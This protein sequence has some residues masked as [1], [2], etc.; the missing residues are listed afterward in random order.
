M[1]QQG[2]EVEMQPGC[3]ATRLPVLSPFLLSSAAAHAD[4]PLQRDLS[5]R[6]PADKQVNWVICRVSLATLTTDIWNKSALP[7]E[8]ASQK[9]ASA[10]TQLPAIAGKIRLNTCTAGKGH[11][12]DCRTVCIPGRQLKLSAYQAASRHDVKLADCREQMVLAQGQQAP[13][14]K[15]R[16]GACKGTNT[17][18][19]LFSLVQKSLPS[20]CYTFMQLIQVSSYS[21]EVTIEVLQ[22]DLQGWLIPL[23]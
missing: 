3:C 16:S 12:C 1:E 14:A 15:A 2:L 9:V 23:L 6:L 10:V 8:R 19:H 11:G 7:D 21:H 20:V 4:L 17:R 18:T 13:W 22:D 5:N